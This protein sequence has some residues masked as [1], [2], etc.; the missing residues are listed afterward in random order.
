[1]ALV[2]V[3]GEESHAER[4]QTADHLQGEVATDE[5]AQALAEISLAEGD[6]GGHYLLAQQDDADGDQDA[7]SAAP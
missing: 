1:M 2:A 7:C 6:Q 4:E 3:G 5:D